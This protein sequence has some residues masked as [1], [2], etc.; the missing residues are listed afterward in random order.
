MRR[1]PARGDA[2]AIKRGDP[3]GGEIPPQARGYSRGRCLMSCVPPVSVGFCSRAG[4]Y[5]LALNSPGS[6]GWTHVSPRLL[7]SVSF[8][9]WGCSRLIASEI[10]EKLDVPFV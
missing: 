6:S 2:S 4:M 9:E 3:L 8:P 10:M 1:L 7:L 5:T